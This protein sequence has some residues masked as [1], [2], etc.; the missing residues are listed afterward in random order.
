M[1][2]NAKAVPLEQYCKFPKEIQGVVTDSW[3]L[4][5]RDFF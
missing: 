3:I 4:M 1:E 5:P 2:R